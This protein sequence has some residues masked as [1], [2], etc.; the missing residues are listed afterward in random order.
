[1][2]EASRIP[3]VIDACLAL[4]TANLTGVMVADGPPDEDLTADALLAVGSGPDPDI[5]TGEQAAAALGALSRNER[6]S[7]ECAVS[8]FADSMREARELAFGIFADVQHVHF[9]YP[10]LTADGSNLVRFAEI[11]RYSLTQRRGAHGCN[12]AITYTIAFSAR[13]TKE[14]P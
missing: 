7:L 10:N 1:M 11:T 12:A 14:Q 8:V 5:S 13:L 2:A 3:A 4:Y 9:A 6:V